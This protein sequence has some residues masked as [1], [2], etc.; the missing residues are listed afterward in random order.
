MKIREISLGSDK[1]KISGHI[2]EL[3]FPSSTTMGNMYVCN[4]SK[5]T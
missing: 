3:N 5:L 2:T 4:K 1:E